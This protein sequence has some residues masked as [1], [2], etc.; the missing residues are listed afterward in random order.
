[1]LSDV[2]FFKCID[3][4]ADLFRR[5]S[6]Q[7]T[8]HYHYTH[9]SHYSLSQFIGAPLDIDFGTISAKQVNI[10]FNANSI[11]TGIGH[12]DE[13]VIMFPN[14]LFTSLTSYEDITASQALVGLWTSFAAKG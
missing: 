10:W 11:T 12:A 4:S 7:S 2:N 8:Y 6:E 13:L 1:M 14:M 3:D 9:R 5:Y